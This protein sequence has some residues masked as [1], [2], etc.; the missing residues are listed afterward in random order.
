MSKYTFLDMNPGHDRSG[1][2]VAMVRSGGYVMVKRPRCMPFV[3]AEGDW[4]KL[5]KTAEEG[6]GFSLRNGRVIEVGK[7][8]EA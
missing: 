8:S 4:V 5:P 1:K 2:I 7:E 6:A 3:M